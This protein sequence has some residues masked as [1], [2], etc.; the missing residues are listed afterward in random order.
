[1]P[2]IDPTTIEH[3]LTVDPTHNPV[4]RSK[5]H[6]GPKRAAVAITEVQKLLEAGFVGECQYPEWISNVVLVKKPNGT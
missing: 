3:M 1:M 4:V 2:I 5:R 6:M